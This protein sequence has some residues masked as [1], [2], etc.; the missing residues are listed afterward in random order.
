MI[1]HGKIVAKLKEL[2]PDGMI[3]CKEA[4]HL[5]QELGVDP[6]E[7]GEACDDAEVKISSCELGCF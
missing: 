1:D 2:F 7:V 6:R 5:A 3:T 4:R